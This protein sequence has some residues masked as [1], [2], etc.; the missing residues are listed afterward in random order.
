MRTHPPIHV[1]T[2]DLERLE[3]LLEQS[4]KRPE[5]A[6]LEDEL[7]RAEVIEVAAVPPDLITMN[8]R[9]RY[10]EEDT[11]A[12]REVTVVF[13]HDADTSADRV[14]VLAPIGSALLGLSVGDTID[15]PVPHGRTTRIRVVGVPY[16]PEAAGHHHV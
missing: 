2:L 9:V 4:A 5:A 8:S 6:R 11:G 15:W 3:R 10:V 14:S 7:A 1:S 13:P 16:Q 12:V